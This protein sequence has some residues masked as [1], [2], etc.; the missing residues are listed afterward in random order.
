MP[1]FNEDC[2]LLVK[3]QFSEGEFPKDEISVPASLARQLEDK[4]REPGRRQ[5]FGGGVS[6]GALPVPVSRGTASNC[7][8]AT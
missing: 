7:A 4:E 1:A 6:L 8:M 3:Q 2:S 5:E